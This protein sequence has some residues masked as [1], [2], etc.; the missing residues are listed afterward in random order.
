[1]TSGPPNE[2]QLGWIYDYFTEYYGPCF[3]AN[4]IVVPPA[5]SRAEFIANWPNPGWFPSDD[6]A[7]ADPERDAALA[8]AC[9]DPD[10]AIMSGVVD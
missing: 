6:R 3:E 7:V 5:P 1:M 8:E 4:D 10:T 2:A 9:V